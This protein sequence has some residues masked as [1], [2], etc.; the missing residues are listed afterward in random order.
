[1]LIDDDTLQWHGYNGGH[2]KSNSGAG[3][4]C[5]RP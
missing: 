3:S 5:N 2:A 1:M 4:K